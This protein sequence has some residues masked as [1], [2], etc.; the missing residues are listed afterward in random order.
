MELSKLI[1]G[2][3]VEPLERSSSDF[4]VRVCDLTE[5]SRTAMPGS[6]FIARAGTN[7]EGA[8]YIDQAVAAG[9]VAV[10]TDNPDAKAPEGYHPVILYSPDACG[11]GAK[12]AERFYGHPSDQ[13][14]IAG[15]TGTNGKTTIAH[16]TQQ[17]VKHAHINEHRIKCGLIGTVQIDDGRECS[18]APMTT[19]PAIELSRTLSTMVEHGCSACAMEV[20]SHA[21]SQKRTYALAIDAAGFTNLTGD[22]LDYHKTIDSYTDAKASFFSHLN[23]GSL[24]IINMDDPAG[25]IMAGVCPTGVVV[26]SCSLT[27]HEADWYGEIVSRS[28]DGVQL[29]IHSPLGELEC[30]V[31][32]FGDYNAS[33]T[34]IAMGLSARLLSKLGL[35]DAQIIE[36]WKQTLPRLKL[37]SGRLECVHTNDDD[38]R[39]FVD[40]AHSDDS[41]RNCLSGVRSVLPSGS[42]LWCVFG[43]GGDRDRT[44]RPRMGQEACSGADRVVLTSDNPR[45]EKPS[46]I[47]DDVLAGLDEAQ[48]ARVEV[49]V[50][51]ARA[52]QFAIEKAAPGD[53]IVIAGK[54]HEPE[55]IIADQSGKLVHYVFDDRVHAREALDER[56]FKLEVNA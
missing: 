53:V 30:V 12:L 4:S 54:G 50:D 10:V 34:V 17:I 13:L 23:P 26:Q 28:L 43:C 1:E 3:E 25:K 56:R 11:I 9:A 35:S 7:D 21:L 6:L 41:I 5:D 46:R 40:F 2:I 55:Q 24:A 37:P 33:N 45:S 39:V 27:D 44:K 42:K 49:Q 14:V 29:R 38:L 19:P 8:K 47:V 16:L 31:P 22:H 15:V 18:A 20:S 32:F 52:I 36:H 48:R 51:R